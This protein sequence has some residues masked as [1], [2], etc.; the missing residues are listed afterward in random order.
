MQRTDESSTRPDARRAGLNSHESATMSQR[1]E[2]QV[3]SDAHH[4]DA[5]DD[6]MAAVLRGKTGAERLAMASGMF[7]LARD[8][9]AGHVRSEHPDW[10]E[11][12]IAKEVARRLSHGA[13]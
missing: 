10:D 3:D 4:F 7:A 12:R 8:L 1:P 9:I 2:L 11:Q 13:V 5:I 6:E